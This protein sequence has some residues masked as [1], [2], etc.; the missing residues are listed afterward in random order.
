MESIKKGQCK[1]IILS[2]D[3]GNNKCVD[4]GKENPTKV[5]VNNGVILCEECATQHS[6]LGSMISYIRDLSDGF[7][8]YFTLGGNYKFKKFLNEENVDASLPINKKYL[9]KACDFYRIN[10][11]KKVQGDKLLEKNYENPNEIIEN[12]ENHFP[13]FDNYV[14][15]IQNPKGNQ[16]KMEQAK[17][18]LGTLEQDYS[19]LEKKCIL[20]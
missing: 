7:D 11:K 12:P 13:E 19:V 9:T 18:V 15:K 6:Q 5:S 8:D 17:K 14:L 4:C 10:L 16:T 1:D 20:E 2:I 3:E